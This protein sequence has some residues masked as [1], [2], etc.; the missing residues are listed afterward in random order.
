MRRVACARKNQEDLIVKSVLRKIKY[1]RELLAYVR[2]LESYA[3]LQAIKS[4]TFLLLNLK[5]DFFHT[6]LN[7]YL[8]LLISKHGHKCVLI[9]DSVE[10]SHYDNDFY[11]SLEYIKVR[12]RSLKAYIY[13]VLKKIIFGFAGLRAEKNIEF[14]FVKVNDLSKILEA[15][16]SFYEKNKEIGPEG[17][18]RGSHYR[19]FG[20]REYDPNNKLHT[21]F[22]YENI[23]N[24]Q[25]IFEACEKVDKNH[26]IDKVLCLDGIYTIWGSCRDFFHDRSFLIYQH[27]GFEDQVLHLDYDPFSVSSSEGDYFKFLHSGHDDKMLSET[28]DLLNQRT[29]IPQDSIGLRQADELLSQ[30]KKIQQERQCQKIVAIYPNLTW[31]GSI[32]E[33]DMVFNGLS[34]WVVQTIKYCIEYNFILILREH[35][36]KQANYTKHSSIISLLKEN[37]SNLIEDERII[38][39]DALSKVSSF[40]IAKNMADLN[41]VYNGTLIP[42]LAY[43]KLPVLICANS[44]YSGKGVAFE[45]HNVEEYRSG[46]QKISRDNFQSSDESRLMYRSSIIASSFRFFNS[47]FYFPLIPRQKNQGGNSDKYW[48]VIFEKDYLV[49]FPERFEKMIRRVLYYEDLIVREV[50]NNDAKFLYDLAIEKVSRENSFSTNSFTFDDHMNWFS[51]KLK[52]PNSF[53]YIFEA[54]EPIG[55]VRFDADPVKKTADVSISIDKKKRGIRLGVQ[56]INRGL[57]EI[58]KHFY[59]YTIYASVKKKNVASSRLFLRCGFLKDSEREINGVPAII[60]QFRY[61]EKEE[62]IKGELKTLFKVEQS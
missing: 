49:E 58:K 7:Y 24:Y 10:I 37:H 6:I 13:F 56:M 45:A 3:H 5:Y 23:V 20:G 50:E 12:R 54:K 11:T 15:S 18:Y 42:E 44:P 19:Y 35:P 51:E 53:I 21:E 29:V 36:E 57:M 59:D 17:H 25:I 38:L 47:S 60:Y 43:L 52:N 46:L 8:A 40:N 27:T 16:K 26:H 31:D 39:V 41:L 33:R 34:D 1:T 30:A 55:Y 14:E 4:K 61:T 2:S 32:G 62:A 48:K 28:I 22:F 9:S